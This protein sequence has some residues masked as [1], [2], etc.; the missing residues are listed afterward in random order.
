MDEVR[1][2][3]TTSDLIV[4]LG[5]TASGKTR[6]AVEVAK[7]TD[8]AIISA[9]SRQVYRGMDLGTGKDL[10][11]YG[12]IPY[13]LID[14]REAGETYHVSQYRSDFY[15]ALDRIRQQGKQP[16]LCG[17]TGLYIQSVLQRFDYS[18]VPVDMVLRSELEALDADALRD[19]LRQLPMP[20]GFKADTSTRKRLI[21]ATEICTWCQYHVLP[22]HHHPVVPA[23]L[24][25][26]NP[27][28]DIRRQRIT[29]RLRARLGQGLIEEV[30]YLLQKG[31][32]PER[33]VYY[34]LE[35][36]YV[37]RYLLGEL[38]DKTFFDRLN[39]EIHRFA[40]RQ[41]TY[42]RKMEKDGLVIHWLTNGSIDDMATEVMAISAII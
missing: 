21:R 34:G 37:T 12:D 8:G 36:K 30:K 26:I 41:M 20:L 4:I 31:I 5:P 17:G 40:K 9:D 22:Q 28:I 3:K 18:G 35:Y 7:R 33:L 23:L 32:P 1:G 42:F 6:L 11:D 24:F 14:I 39:T 25:G 19:R 38:D 16:I 13:F 15:D 10:D 29:E 27:P 2:V